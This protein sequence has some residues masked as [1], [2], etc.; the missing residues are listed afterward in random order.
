MTRPTT[1]RPSR[2][3]ALG[4]VNKREMQKEIE[5]LR[6]ENVSLQKQ[7]A[8]TVRIL[9]NYDRIWMER[10]QARAELKRLKND[11]ATDTN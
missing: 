11:Q 2:R 10:D 7:K 5:R 1:N 9:Q 3:N 4:T 6:A 8:E